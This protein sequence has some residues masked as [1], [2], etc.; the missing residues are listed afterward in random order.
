MLNIEILLQNNVSYNKYK[1]SVPSPHK[2]INP[3]TTSVIRTL[4]QELT[5]FIEQLFFNL[6]DSKNYT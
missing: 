1:N 2:T 3:L 6:F 4:P 5:K